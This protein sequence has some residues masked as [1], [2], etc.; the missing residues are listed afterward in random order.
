[1]Y[2]NSIGE[3]SSKPLLRPRYRNTTF[4]ALG[5]SLITCQAA[6]PDGLTGYKNYF[7]LS[8]DVCQTTP[9]TFSA[10]VTTIGH[11][12]TAHRFLYILERNH[13]ICDTWTPP[14]DHYSQLIYKL[15]RSRCC[16]FVVGDVPQPDSSMPRLHSV[17]NL[18]SSFD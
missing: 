17:V 14:C 4:F 15:P 6:L 13:C 16:S 9:P 8:G 10:S 7:G 18:V 2:C 12:D 1:M 11:Y 5:W 3:P